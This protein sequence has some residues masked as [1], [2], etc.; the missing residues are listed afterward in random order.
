MR[1][2]QTTSPSG[3]VDTLVD[4]VLQLEGDCLYMVQAALAQRYPILWPAATRW[5]AANQSVVSPAGS[6]MPIGT[7]VQGR[8]GYFYLSDVHLLG[9]TA[10]SNRAASCVDNSYQQVVVVK[11]TDAAIGPKP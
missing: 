6:V 9:G 4:G 10:A 5:D 8:G 3:D 1:F 7:A 2:L 11:N